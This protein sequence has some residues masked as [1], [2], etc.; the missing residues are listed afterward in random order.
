GIRDFHVTGVQTCALPIYGRHQDAPP[1]GN[2]MRT[3]TRSS[4]VAVGLGAISAATAV[5]LA[6]TTAPAAAHAAGHDAAPR[7]PQT[8]Q[9]PVRTEAP[10]TYVVRPGDTVSA[11]AARHGTTV[12]AVVRA[13]GLDKRAVIRV[14]QVL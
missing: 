13:N 2:R 10:S 1:W 12:A 3:R 9:I 8:A 4:K 7:G 14:G 6:G 5:G 11:I